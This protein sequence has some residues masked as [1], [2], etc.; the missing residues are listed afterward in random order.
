MT[1]PIQHEKRHITQ[2]KH[3][4]NLLNEKCFPD[5][6]NQSNLG[7]KDWMTTVCFYTALHYVEAYLHINGILRMNVPLYIPDVT[8]PLHH[9]HVK[10]VRARGGLFNLRIL[11]S[12]DANTAQH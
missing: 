5:P 1:L 6:C 4:D 10:R 8:I 9:C 12:H 7:Y 11:P 2:A 3:N